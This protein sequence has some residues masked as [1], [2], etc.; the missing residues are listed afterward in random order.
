M[1]MSIA[2]IALASSRHEFQVLAISLN[3]RQML[4]AGPVRQILLWA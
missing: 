1:M 2:F 4:G 3:A